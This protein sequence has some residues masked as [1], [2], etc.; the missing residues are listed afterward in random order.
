MKKNYKDNISKGKS[1]SNKSK[2]H[3]ANHSVSYYSSSKDIP[4]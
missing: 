4:L 2:T 3:I 1:L